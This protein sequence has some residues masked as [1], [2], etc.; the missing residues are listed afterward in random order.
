[1]FS[2]S[3]SLDPAR[4]SAALATLLKH[5]DPD[6]FR[7]D[8]RRLRQAFALFSSYCPP[9]WPAPGLIVPPEVHYLSEVWLPLALIRPSF[10]RLYR[11]ALTFPPVLS[12]TP[13][14]SAASWAALVAAMP[15]RLCRGGNP[16]LLMERLLHDPV[17]LADF[18]FWSF[19]PQRF[20]GGGAIRYPQQA[21]F[22]E[23]LIGC[24]P[25]DRP[26]RCLDAACGDGSDSYRLTGMLLDSGR[27]ADRFTV[28]GWTLDPLEV[29]A[30]AHAAVPLD[31]AHQAVLR[32]LAQ[33]V[34]DRRGNGSML[35]RQ[36]DLREPPGQRER[37][38]LVVCNGLLGGPILHRA[39][40][41]ETVARNLASLLR[42]G[43]MLLAA[44]RFHGGWKKQVPRECLGNLLQGCGLAVWEA[45]EGLA[46]VKQ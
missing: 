19:M 7:A 34:F 26:L 32:E 5:P 2:F 46:A 42:P 11:A 13:F 3:P 20:Y 6:L 23:D 15:D 25:A 30:A 40:Q 10:E 4:A 8:A 1:M 39:G 38:D 33:P 29:W 21:L 14:A 28:E 17:L 16:A 18:L 31:G 12:S 45:G 37:F 36:A 22:L 9:P 43:G 24:F 35:F 44:D 27:S 41:I